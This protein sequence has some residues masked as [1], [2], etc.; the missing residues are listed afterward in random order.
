MRGAAGENSSKQVDMDGLTIWNDLLF[1]YSSYSS[2]LFIFTFS[3]SLIAAET[4][5]VQG[6]MNRHS[7]QW[8]PKVGAVHN[9][10]FSLSYNNSIQ[11]ILY[12]A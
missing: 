7:T 3:S 8:I 12:I 5:I 6:E 9:L 4:A 11:N 2:L 10:F 1:Y